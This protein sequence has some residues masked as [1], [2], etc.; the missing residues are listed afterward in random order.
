MAKTLTQKIIFKNAKPETFDMFLN[1]KHHA[2]FTGG[3]TTKIIAKE[4]VKFSVYDGYITGKNL[5][6][7][8]GKLIVQSW[9]G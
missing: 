5:Q 4:G 6:L 9:L 1:A 7:V 3:G 8:R 2:A